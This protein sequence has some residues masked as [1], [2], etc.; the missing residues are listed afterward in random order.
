[1]ELILREMMITLEWP[2]PTFN[3][4]RLGSGFYVCQTYLCPNTKDAYM[5]LRTLTI[6]GSESVSEKDALESSCTAAILHLETE[7]S[8]RLFDINYSERSDGEQ[9][10]IK[11]QEALRSAFFMG[12]KVL[13]QWQVMVNQIEA[14]KEYCLKLSEENSSKG[15]ANPMCRL[16]SDSIRVVRE[17]HEACLTDMRLAKGRLKNGGA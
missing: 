4:F 8:I 10:V 6:A 7:L 15:K 5:E 2:E 12:W 11:A 14:C 9:A 16:I 17:L 1:M 13:A 3:I